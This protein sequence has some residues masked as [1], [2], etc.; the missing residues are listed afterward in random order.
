MH[1]GLNCIL[2]LVDS[3]GHH[4]FVD[5]G[6]SRQVVDARGVLQSV[7]H[8]LEGLEPDLGSVHE[9]AGYS[10]YS[11]NQQVNSEALSY[12]LITML[13]LRRSAGYSPSEYYL[14]SSDICSFP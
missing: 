5:D 6:L 11:P 14:P 3:V 13:L 12:D 10:Q 7:R 1:K 2:E 8:L 4:S 9:R